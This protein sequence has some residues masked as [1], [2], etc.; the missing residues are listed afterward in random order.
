MNTEKLQV[1]P[2]AV[3][4]ETESKRQRENTLTSHVSHLMFPERS[5]SL[6]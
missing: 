5:K 6:L 1:R 4:E 3:R 2:S